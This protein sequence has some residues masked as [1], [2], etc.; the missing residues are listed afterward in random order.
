[1]RLAMH[2]AGKWSISNMSRNVKG[3]KSYEIRRRWLGII[4]T[5]ISDVIAAV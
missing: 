2:V 3:L 1:M 4:T 5:D